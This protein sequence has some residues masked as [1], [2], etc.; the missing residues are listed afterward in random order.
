MNEAIKVTTLGGLVKL[1]V[2]VGAATYVLVQRPRRWRVCELWSDWE[3][4]ER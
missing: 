3:W 1:L 2:P 4:E